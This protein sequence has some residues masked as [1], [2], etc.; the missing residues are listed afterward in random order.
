MPGSLRSV[1]TGVLISFGDNEEFPT[2][3]S[4]TKDATWESVNAITGFSPILGFSSSSAMIVA[5]TIKFS[6]EEGSVM[7]RVHLCRSLVVP[8]YSKGLY[9]PPQVVLTIDN[10]LDNFKGVVTSIRVSIPEDAAWVHLDNSTGSGAEPTTV[11][12]TFSIQECDVSMQTQ[13]YGQSYSP[14]NFDSG[15]SA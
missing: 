6:I 7:E 2:G 12:V 13:V 3:I 1:E 5:F 14:T 10:Y 8:D 4:D 15:I 9:R 11:D